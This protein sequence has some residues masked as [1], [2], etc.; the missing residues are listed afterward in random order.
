MTVII[1]ISAPREGSITTTHTKD[2]FRLLSQPYQE[3]SACLEHCK[4]GTWGHAFFCGMVFASSPLYLGSCW[5][6]SHVLIGGF[7]DSIF[8]EAMYP[9]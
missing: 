9:E 2:C 3:G 5:Q 4:P 6:D 8:P 7:H 1:I